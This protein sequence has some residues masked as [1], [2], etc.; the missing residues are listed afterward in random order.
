LGGV[1]LE[2]RSHTQPDQTRAR[3]HGSLAWLWWTVGILASVLLL[4]CL[5]GAWMLYR[6]L[7]P[8]M[9]EAFSA[10]IAPSAPVAASGHFEEVGAVPQPCYA[11][12][13]D[14]TRGRWYA[15]TRDAFLVL[16]ATGQVRARK[17]MPDSAIGGP[18][19]GYSTLRLLNVD[20]DPD[21][22]LLGFQ[23]WG[24][25]VD[26]LDGNGT[27]LWSYRTESGVADAWGGDL[28]G[29]GLDEVGLGLTG[30]SG[31]PVL[32][33]RGAVLW[34]D[35]SLGNTWSVCIADADGDGA[36]EVV[37]GP[38]EVLLYDA[39]GTRLAEWDAA[40]YVNLVR[41]VSTPG[42]GVTLVAG[43]DEM[44]GLSA[45]GVR[46][47]SVETGLTHTVG[48]DMASSRPWLALVSM[49]GVV[50][51]IYVR[52]GTGL[53]SETLGGMLSAIAWYDGGSGDPS[54]LVSDG[55]QVRVC[56]VRGVE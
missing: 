35:P 54:L 40:G 53:A 17:P 13:A 24:R 41:P 16:D 1:L 56:K 20:P 5:G 36:N 12:A 26:V 7:R 31:M 23:P 37:A 9:A 51:V 29:D 27:L 47:W 42:I 50:L 28:D 52:Y 33:S 10:E 45:A 55:S 30:S 44:H 15:A 11:L 22:E 6:V 19:G 3:T 14:G 48:S 38:S 39:Q 49:D 4:G 32:T 25:S 34:T 46:V 43:A 2:T 21:P 8:A 18:A